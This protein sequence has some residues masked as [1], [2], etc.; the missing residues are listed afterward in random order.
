MIVTRTPLRVSFA[1]GFSDVVANRETG[2]NGCVLSATV[3]FYATVVLLPRY[4]SSVV[5]SYSHIERVQKVRDLRHD[6]FRESLLAFGIEDGV[7]VHSIGN[8][9]LV[10]GGMGGS[11]AIVVGLVSALVRLRGMRSFPRYLAEKAADIELR[12]LGKTIGKQDHYAAAFGGFNQFTFAGGDVEV[13]P[14]EFEELAFLS[15]N[16]AL[17]PIRGRDSSASEILKEQLRSVPSAAIDRLRQLVP[18]ARN[19]I[20]SQSLPGIIRVLNE[21]WEA[22]KSVSPLVS[23]PEVDDAIDLVRRLGG[24]GKLCG[25]GGGGTVFAIFPDGCLPDA[26]GI[27]RGSVPCPFEPSGST[28]LFDNW[29]VRT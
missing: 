17:I 18:E 26:L 25:A 16:A 3:G 23:C 24:A 29:G 13:A 11:S 15:Q 21:S 14:C 6:L 9:P 27:F 1:G 20:R 10:S 12:T 4:D 7:E 22:K 28:V 8:L 2:R 5:A 19:A